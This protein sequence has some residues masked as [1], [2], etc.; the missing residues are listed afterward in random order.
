[1]APSKA[2]VVNG[3][4]ASSDGDTTALLIAAEPD[5]FNEHWVDRCPISTLE[6][7]DVNAQDDDDTVRTEK[8]GAQCASLCGVDLISIASLDRKVLFFVLIAATCIVQGV[9]QLL[10]V[11]PSG[12]VTYS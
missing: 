5:A 9:A 2:G 1:M 11:S 12:L 6:S 7:G 4:V 3:S 8:P 10:F